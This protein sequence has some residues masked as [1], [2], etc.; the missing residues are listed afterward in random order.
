LRAK[1]R[2]SEQKAKSF[3]SFFEREYDSTLVKGNDFAL[4]FDKWEWQKLNDMS[5]FNFFNLKKVVY[6]QNS[7]DS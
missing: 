4:N 1:V 7:L 3:L 6:A 2:I 5:F